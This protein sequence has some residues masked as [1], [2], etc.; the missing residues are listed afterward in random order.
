MSHDIA[1]ELYYLAP[2]SHICLGAE[3][4]LAPFLLSSWRT[5]SS[6]LL[7]W[8]RSANTRGSNAT[9]TVGEQ[10]TVAWRFRGPLDPSLLHERTRLLDHSFQ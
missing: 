1:V 7:R 10:L 3:G 2:L 5:L 6:S 9:L 8:L 4:T